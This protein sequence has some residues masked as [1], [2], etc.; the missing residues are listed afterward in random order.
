MP[1]KGVFHDGV[2]L[3]VDD[4]RH[5]GVHGGRRHVANAGVPMVVVVPGEKR[6]AEGTRIG[7]RIEAF[8]ET[9][10]ILQR[11]KLCFGETNMLMTTYCREFLVWRARPMDVND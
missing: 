4:R 3:F 10:P 6:L 7:Q 9:R 1:R 11:L 8:R 5:A 2:A